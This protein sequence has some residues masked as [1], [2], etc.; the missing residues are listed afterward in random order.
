MPAL[1][2]VMSTF[3]KTVTF[4]GDGDFKDASIAVSDRYFTQPCA[5]I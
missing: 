1:V 2:P 3:D 5:A 4:L